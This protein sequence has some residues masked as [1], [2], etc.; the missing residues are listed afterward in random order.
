MG[1]TAPLGKKPCVL[2]PAAWL[3]AR[4]VFAGIKMLLA[5]NAVKRFFQ[6]F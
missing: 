1:C 6:D 4:F 2:C 5:F 3:H